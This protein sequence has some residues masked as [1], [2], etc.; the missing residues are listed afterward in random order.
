LADEVTKTVV[1]TGA[2]SYTGKYVTRLL[3][4]RRYNVRTLTSQPNRPNEFRGAVQAFPFNFDNV[5]KLEQ[6]LEGAKTL[7]NTY[8]VRF[9]KGASTFDSAIANT[10]TLF[11][12]AK[13][14]GIGRIVH[15]SI[16][17]PSEDSKLDYYRGKAVLEKALAQSGLSNCIV[18]P[19][20]IFG[21]EDILIN[22][23]AWFLRK[24]PVFG[25]PGDGKYRVRPIYVEDMATLL[26][27]AVEHQRNEIVDAVGPET[28]TFEE[29]VRTIAAK[30]GRS[31]MVVHLPAF[32]AYAATS[33]VGHLMS[34]TILTWQEYA[35]LMRG[36]LAPE[37]PAT[38]KT[39]LTDW[40]ASHHAQLGVRYS[41][42]VARHFAK[43]HANPVS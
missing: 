23:I 36:L 3:L 1:I 29:L 26:A 43:T 37:G 8:W 21:R 16:A 40:L 2:L 34:D 42:E 33:L 18:R 32:L 7:I 13:S 38:G 28:F 25:L 17:N 4:Q 27:D 5:A 41:S 20:V 30:I 15:V 22:N 6:S 12:A 9:P 39:P 35:G 11:Q 31:P 24:L 10:K 19:T 14:A